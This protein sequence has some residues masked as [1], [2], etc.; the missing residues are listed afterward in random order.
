MGWRTERRDVAP[1]PT[2]LQ[3]VIQE[4]DGKNY[5]DLDASQVRAFQTM[6]SL[7]YLQF[8]EYGNISPTE[9]GRGIIDGSIKTNRE[10]PR[11]LEEYRSESKEA[12]RCSTA[13]SQS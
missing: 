7:W 9:R 6:R 4:F 3:I 11:F 10:I 2:P 13:G 12:T 8:D 1:E 5:Y